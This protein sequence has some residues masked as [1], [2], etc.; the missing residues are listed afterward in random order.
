MQIKLKLLTVNMHTSLLYVLQHMLVKLT[1]KLCTVNIQ[2][3]I[4]EDEKKPNIKIPSQLWRLGEQNKFLAKFLSNA[5]IEYFA[6]NFKP[7]QSL[8]LEKLL[9]TSV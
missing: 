4:W 3:S 2:K 9:K 7:L 1:I 5:C 8:V 6:Q